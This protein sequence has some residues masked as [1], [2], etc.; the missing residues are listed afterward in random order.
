M[1]HIR[2]QFLRDVQFLQ[3][4]KPEIKGFFG[5]D[6]R[7][8]QTGENFFA[9]IPVVGKYLTLTGCE[10]TVILNSSE[11]EHRG[12][13]SRKGRQ[14]MTVKSKPLPV[15]GVKRRKYSR[16]YVQE[17][18]ELY[19][20]MIPVLILIFL[21]CYLP[22]YGLLIS[23]QNYQPGDP[24]LAFDG[25]IEWVGLKHFTKFI[26]GKYFF[27]LIKNTF[28]LSFLNIAVGFWIPIIFALL[29][30]EIHNLRFKKLIQTASYLPYFI[31]SVVVAGMVLSFIEPNGLVN[32][33]LGIF[34]VPPKAYAMEPKYFAFIYTFTN[35]WK[36]FGWN[37]ILYISAISSIDPSL[38]ES[39]RLDGANR[40]QNIWYMTLPSILPTISIMLVMAVGSVL[41]SNTDLILLLYNPATYKT[42]DVIG[43]YIYRD[44]LESGNFSFA[45]AVG[46]F[47]ATINFILVFAAN[48]ISNRLT[49][50]G[51]W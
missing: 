4:E 30:N 10:N 33:L 24:F 14:F 25:S 28:V 15:A 7:A 48:W 1:L 39:S 11:T 18:L 22:L 31:S 6:N 13:G 23:F 42:A 21:F 8:V 12:R 5:L 29:L 51:L 50:Y 38:Y 43:T 2:D 16:E 9:N 41:A 45:S 40:F 19:A 47:T 17:N 26:S 49:N 27:R 34:G 32:H 20:I 36:S 35:I 46:V 37:S 3:T 44:G